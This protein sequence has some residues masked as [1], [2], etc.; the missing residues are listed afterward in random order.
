M[1]NIKLV[2]EYDGTRYCGFQ[3]QNKHN[4]I[5]AELEKALSQLLNEKISIISSGRTDSGVHAAGHVVNFTTTKKLKVFNIIRGLNTLL[6]EDIAVK[7]AQY[8]SS[9]FHARF[10]AKGKIYVYNLW[11]SERRSPLKRLYCYQ[12]FFPLDCKKMREAAFRLQGKHDFRAFGTQ[13]KGKENTV[14]TIKRIDIRKKGNLIR[15]II[16]GDG[17][18]YN[19]VRNIV[20]TLVWVGRGKLGVNDVSL[21]LAAQDRT[22]VPPTI[23]ACGLSL[24]KVIY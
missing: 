17:F 1:A 10:S 16:E 24:V 22:K 20:G 14:R 21:L 18:L 6:P 5:Q 13:S 12:Y 7:R 9:S 3:K 19:M 2:I 15:F 23:S 4:T 11:N 8:I